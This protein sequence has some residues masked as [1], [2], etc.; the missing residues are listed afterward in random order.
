MAI[1]DEFYRDNPYRHALKKV[2]LLLLKKRGFEGYS[3]KM[4]DRP[5]ICD[6][7]SERDAAATHHRLC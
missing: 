7:F 2:R 1:S 5:I 4:L 6:K 3:M